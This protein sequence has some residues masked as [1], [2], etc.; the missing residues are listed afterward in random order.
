MQNAVISEDLT[1]EG[2]I[3]ARETNL[4]VNGQITGDVTTKT[5]DVKPGGTVSGKVTAE[6]ATIG[7]TLKGE[8]TCDDLTLETTARVEADLRAKALTSSKGAAL[9]GK[10]EIGG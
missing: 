6:S 2:D 9:T 10:V 5:L 8:V 1:I 7:G 4:T 3:I